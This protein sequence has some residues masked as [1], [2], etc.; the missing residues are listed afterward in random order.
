VGDNDALLLF[1][2]SPGIDSRE[3]MPGGYSSGYLPRTLPA[4]DL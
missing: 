3:S 2:P 4:A 1:V